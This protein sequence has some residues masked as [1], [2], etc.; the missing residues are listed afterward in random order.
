MFWIYFNAFSLEID[1]CLSS[2]CDPKVGYSCKN[3]L[4]SYECTCKKGF[5]SNGAR[6]V[7]TYCFILV[8][9]SKHTKPE[10][11]YYYKR[12]PGIANLLQV[13]SVTKLL[14]RL[15]W[16]GAIPQFLPFFNVAC[17]NALYTVQA[18]AFRLFD[19]I[20]LQKQLWNRGDITSQFAISWTKM[21]YLHKCLKF[22]CHWL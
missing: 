13:Q 22:Q 21:P 6:C 18:I 7:G 16:R 8:E 3:V 17:Q 20:S 14:N 10:E 5:S 19:D 4:G 12:C 1:E 15:A 9:I 2:P 11:K